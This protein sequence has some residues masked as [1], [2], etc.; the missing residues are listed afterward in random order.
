[1]KKI[2]L[3]GLLVVVGFVAYV[4]VPRSDAAR[5]VAACENEDIPAT[6]YERE[7]PALYPEK[8]LTDIF[9]TIREI[10]RT[11]TSYQF[12]HVVAHKLG[13]AVVAEDPEAWL[14]AFAYNP[15]DGLCSNG[16]LHGIIVGRFR[17]DVLTDAE[18]R[19]ATPDF[20][21]ACEPRDDWSPT[22]LDQAMCYHALGHLFMF[23]TSADISKS[24]GVCDAI[25]AMPTGGYHRLCREGVFMQIYQPLEPDD[26]ALIEMLPEKPTPENYRRLCAAYEKDEDEGACLREAWPLAGEGMFDGTAVTAFCSGQPNETEER[27]CYEAATAIIGRLSLG[28]EG[29]ADACAKLLPQW[30]PLC[31]VSV[32]QAIIEEDRTQGEAA[33]AECR[34]APA[35]AARECEA[36]L[37]SRADFILGNSPERAAFCDAVSTEMQAM[38]NSTNVPLDAQ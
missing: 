15:P 30:Q 33:L 26:F 23:I 12:C 22:R 1:M 24:L 6:C 11:D 37:A 19:A 14:R 34:R 38:C 21:T 5:I 2:F 9:K 10:R 28:K 35:H 31:Y 8:S 25:Q 27:A 36:T 16:F 32:A 18:L 7:V 29:R 3:L 20:A 17:S 13:E 4:F